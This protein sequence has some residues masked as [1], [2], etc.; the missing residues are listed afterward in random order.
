[1]K[2][3]QSSGVIILVVIVVL[4]SFNIQISLADPTPKQGAITITFDDGWQSQFDYALPLLEEHGMKA[5]FYVSTARVSE[6]YMTVAELQTLQSYGHEIGSHANTHVDFPTLSESEIREEC[7]TSKQMLQSWGLTAKNFAYPD[8]L[9]NDFTDSIVADYFRSA[10]SGFVGPYLLPYPTKQFSLPCFADTSGD[11]VLPILMSMVDQ[12]YSSNGWT[13][14]AFHNIAPN[15][16][17]WQP[18]TDPQVFDSFLDYVQNKGVAVLTIDQA[19]NLAVPTRGAISIQ[20]DNG[21]QTQYDVYYEMLKPRGIVA[22]FFVN[23]ADIDSDPW[24]GQYPTPWMT[25]QQLVELQDEGNEIGSHCDH[26]YTLTALSELQ[27]RQELQDSKDKLLGWGLTANNFAYP[28]GL[29]NDYTDSIVRDYYQ[30]ARSAY[31]SPYLMYFPITD[32][33]QPAYV[34]DT[35][36]STALSDLKEKIDEVSA[37][38]GYMNIVFHYYSSYDVRDGDFASFLDYVQAKGVATITVAEA[39]EFA[40]PPVSVPY[41]TINPISAIIDV[42]CSVECL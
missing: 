32:F 34:A 3:I 27:I 36:Q 37:A 19:L 30:S 5:T 12:A 10:R 25:H 41:V 9:R 39:L 14:I 24:P 29:R 11:E 31:V 4:A 13:I 2:K 23:T 38:N 35:G 1:M 17:Y 26:H 33:V 22:T 28:E 42:T 15:P 7:Q 21:Y 16:G 6:P 18:N 8:G 20:F 40:A